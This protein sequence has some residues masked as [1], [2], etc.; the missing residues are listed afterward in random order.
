MKLSVSLVD[1]ETNQHIYLPKN[2]GHNKDKLKK[3]ALKCPNCKAFLHPVSSAKIKNSIFLFDTLDKRY[4]NL[5]RNNLVYCR[6]CHHLIG[7]IIK[8]NMKNEADRPPIGEYG[9]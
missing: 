3:P 5:P 7:E 9:P 2:K 6:K 1:F 4:E 8:Q